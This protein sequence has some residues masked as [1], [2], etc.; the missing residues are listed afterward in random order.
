MRSNKLALISALSTLSALDK[1]TIRYATG[2][3]VEIEP[4]DIEE[5]QRGITVNQERLEKYPWVELIPK[6][7]LYKEPKQ[8]CPPKE[9]GQNKKRKN[10]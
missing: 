1:A 6:V 2:K 4:V 3:S 10:R 5:L 8:T 7:K 9:W